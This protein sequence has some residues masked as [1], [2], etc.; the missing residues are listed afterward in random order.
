MLLDP[1]HK[2]G[3][4][5]IQCSIAKFEDTLNPTLTQSKPCIASGV[6]LLT[7]MEDNFPGVTELSAAL[8]ISQML[9]FA[10]FVSLLLCRGYL[11][12]NGIRFGDKLCELRLFS[13]LPRPGRAEQIPMLLYSYI[14]QF[15]MLIHLLS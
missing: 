3:Q 2:A 5:V 14:V 6:T 10:P 4:I 11:L 13:P 9:I 1:F 7:V 8:Q 12:Q 15:Y